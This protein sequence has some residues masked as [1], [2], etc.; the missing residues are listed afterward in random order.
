MVVLSDCNEEDSEM[1]KA[2]SYEVHKA[3]GKAMRK[4]VG[5]VVQEHKKTGRPLTIWKKGKVVQIS[6]NQVKI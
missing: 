2:K 4:A 6:A 5:K 1:I 3:A